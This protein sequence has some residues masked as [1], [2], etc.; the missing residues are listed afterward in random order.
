MSVSD[1]ARPLRNADRHRHSRLILSCMLCAALLAIVGGHP[2]AQ[3][4]SDARWR[5]IKQEL[6][7]D[8][9]VD[10]GADVIGLTTPYR[11]EDAAVV[12]VEMVSKIEPTPERFI[13]GLYL[14]V[15]NNPSPVAAMFEFPGQRSWDLLSTRVRVNAYT[16]V[17]VVAELN[18]GALYMTANYVKASG[19]CSAPA[20]KDPSA[21]MAHL[22]KMKLIVPTTTQADSPLLAKLLIKHPNSSGLQF[23]QIKRNY[24]PADYVRNIEVSY[25]GEPLFKVTTDISISED[26]VIIF[27]FMPD[28]DADG[29]FE[30]HVLDSEGRR[31][32]ERFG[33]T[34]MND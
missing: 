1:L 31:F 10:D 22:G 20:L 14:V 6:F 3:D 30:V 5:Q 21:A 18:D 28:G 33:P 2:R 4:Q 16:H 11:A 15:D 23:D 13:K 29:A 12:P 25:E 34:A 32:D 27:G 17:R 19:G 9:R 7:G 26:P 8:R 24:I